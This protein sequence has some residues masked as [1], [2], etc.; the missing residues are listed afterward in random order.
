VLSTVVALALSVAVGRWGVLPGE[1]SHWA[2]DV[3]VGFA[4]GSAG[5]A[6]ATWWDL[7]YPPRV[8]VPAPDEPHALSDLTL[9]EGP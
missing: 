9:K 8:P 3:V 4:L 1:D 2:G 7:T 5:A 6:A